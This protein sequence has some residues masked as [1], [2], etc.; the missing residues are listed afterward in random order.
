MDALRDDSEIARFNHT[1]GRDTAW[2]GAQ[3]KTIERRMD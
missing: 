2:V 3:V 1:L